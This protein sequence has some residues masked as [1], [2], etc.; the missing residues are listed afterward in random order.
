MHEHFLLGGITT[1]SPSNT[2]FLYRQKKFAYIQSFLAYPFPYLFPRFFF[3]LFPW[4]S[5]R[6][7]STS[8]PFPYP[9]A[10]L[11][12][13]RIIILRDSCR[14]RCGACMIMYCEVLA[15]GNDLCYCAWI[16][17]WK[18]TKLNGWQMHE[19]ILIVSMRVGKNNII[20]VSIDK[21]FPQD[22]NVI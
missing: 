16:P 5:F 10:I 1:P 14:T 12:L 22:I 7:Y 15:S 8:P 2:L 20:D 9:G 21:C 13:L 6:K 3:H 19:D 11:I 17:G 18:G 4:F